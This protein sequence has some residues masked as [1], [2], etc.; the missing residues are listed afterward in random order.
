MALVLESEQT[1][2]GAAS[3]IYYGI[4]HAVQYNVKVREIEYVQT[5]EMATLMGNWKDE[6][7][8]IRSR[9]MILTAMAE[10]PDDDD[11]EEEEEDGDEAQF[12]DT[13]GEEDELYV[14]TYLGCLTT[15]GSRG[16]I[17]FR[18]NT[19]SSKASLSLYGFVVST[20]WI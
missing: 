12:T 4:H 13:D 10:E 5:E 7:M 15:T 11:G 3:K 16:F 18:L 9:S 1:N 19:T 17:V 20:V 6:R 14:V 2:L 8:V